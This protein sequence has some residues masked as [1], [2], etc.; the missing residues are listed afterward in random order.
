LK[1]STSP[2]FAGPGNGSVL[3]RDGFYTKFVRGGLFEKP[4]EQTLEED[5]IVWGTP[6]TTVTV[7]Y[8]GGAL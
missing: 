1:D 6:V 5:N 8:A 2:C 3:A 7:L 4:V